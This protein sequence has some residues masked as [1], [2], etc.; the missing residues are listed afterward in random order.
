MQELKKTV[1]IQINALT[2]KFGEDIVHVMSDKFGPGVESA[3]A[4]V[5]TDFLGQ[6]FRKMHDPTFKIDQTVPFNEPFMMKQLG[7]LRVKQNE[8]FA[9]N[10]KAYENYQ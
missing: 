4:G 2:S 1:G 6:L 9:Q 7:P 5:S 8:L 10:A 3:M